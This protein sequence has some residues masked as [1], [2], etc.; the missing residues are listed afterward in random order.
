MVFAA[1]ILFSQTASDSSH[2]L[3]SFSHWRT[4]FYKR[5]VGLDE[6]IS[7]GPPKD[8]IPALVKPKFESIVEASDWISE[9]E[10][11]ISIEMG[12]EIKAYPLQ[13]MRF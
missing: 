10:G 2:I 8:G 7:G 4:E 11:V 6:L 5:T 12:E 1:N 13:V 3:K 9:N